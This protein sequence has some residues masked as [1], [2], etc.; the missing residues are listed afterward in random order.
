MEGMTAGA[1][2][3]TAIGYA[4]DQP[5]GVSRHWDLLEIMV[6][7]VEGLGPVEAREWLNVEVDARRAAMEE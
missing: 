7:R 1:L 3:D 4:V 6:R 5:G 2:L